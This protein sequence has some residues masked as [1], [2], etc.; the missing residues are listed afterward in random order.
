M[1]RSVKRRVS[2]LSFSMNKLYRTITTTKPSNILLPTLAIGIAVFLFAGGLY[3]L[4]Q[5]PLAAVYYN[6]RFI[7]L[8]PY[9]S[10]QFVGDSIVA[11]IIYSLG[12]TGLMM[13]YQS[14]R[15]VYK[16]RQAYLMLIVGLALV[17]MAYVFLEET[18]HLKLS[19]GG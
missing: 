19:G 13:T 4:I 18:I 11:A 14:T 17:L 1:S 2:S 9:L 6:N 15:Y 16:P 10:E 7:F 8:N 3:D 12:V 5:R